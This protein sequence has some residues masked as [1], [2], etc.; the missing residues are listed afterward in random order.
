MFADI[1]A[2]RRSD[3]G[4]VVVYSL[5]KGFDCLAHIL[6]LAFLTGYEV[7]NVR[8]GARKWK[9]DSKAFIGDGTLKV[10]IGVEVCTGCASS[11]VA[12]VWFS[13]QW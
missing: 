2:L 8:G 11:E 4:S 3:A 13:C 12:F 5:S 7:D 6:F 9:A 1:S 10:V